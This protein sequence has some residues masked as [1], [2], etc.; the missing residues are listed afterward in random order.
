[1]TSTTNTHTKHQFA[2][3]KARFFISSRLSEV[4]ATASDDTARYQSG[5]SDDRI[6]ELVNK[7]GFPDIKMGHIKRLR[8]SLF[9]PLFVSPANGTGKGSA[10]K[11][12]IT[13]LEKEMADV[14][15]YLTS[16]NPAWKDQ[17]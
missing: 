9:G 1:M 14:Q 7:N 2:D 15:A 16:K 13:A 10:S 8:R 12:R 17:V 6:L 11:S 4:C 3:A 5:W